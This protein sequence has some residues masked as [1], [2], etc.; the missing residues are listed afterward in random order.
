MAPCKFAEKVWN[1]QEAGAQ[2]VSVKSKRTAS[3]S[4]VTLHVHS[5][6]RLV[7][8]MAGCNSS[9]P[10]R[11]WWSSTTRTSTPP[12]RRRTTRTRSPT[13]VCA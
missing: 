9:A 10:S 8:R 12:W 7:Q 4:A 11:R 13:G 3:L 2:G 5:G 1:A 6:I